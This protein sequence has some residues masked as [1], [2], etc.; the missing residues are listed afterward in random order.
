VSTKSAVENP[1]YY[2]GHLSDPADFYGREEQLQDVLERLHKRGS[3]SLV[4]ERKSGK[5][6]LLYYMVTDTA[7]RLYGVGSED[8]VFVYMHP[9]L[10]IGGPAGFFRGLLQKLAEQ[11]PSAIVDMPEEADEKEV[12]AALKRL[13]PRRLVLL[14]DEF[15]DITSRGGFS[16]DFFRILRGLADTYDVCFITATAEE[17]RDCCPDELVSSPFINIFA[18]VRLG[19][20]TEGEF[21]QFMSETSRRSRSPMFACKDEIQRLGGRFPFFVQMACHFYFDAWRR[22]KELTTQGRIAAQHCFTDEA[23]PYLERAWGRHLTAAEKATLISLAHDRECTG[24]PALRT[25]EQKGY[26]LDGHVFSSAL[27][28]LILRKES[29]GEK[30]LPEL[31]TSPQGPVPKGIWMDRT[32]GDVWVD[33]KRIHDLTRLEYKLLRYLYE[34]ANCLCDKYGLVE[35]VWSSDYI[36]KVD[37]P[38]IA[39]LVSRLREDVEPDP[40]NSRYILTVHGRGYR[41]V[42]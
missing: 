17:L 3:T 14:L 38:R 37:D 32:S 33:G 11:V 42:S 10:Q 23:M 26:V 24:Q 13:A 35:A 6:S 19:S 25:L 22:H 2:G 4:G 36:D 34:N 21:D 5:T 1:Y 20:W 27:N 29:S 9:G 39:K 28:D 41:L 15:Q 31:S 12:E 16:S 8:L 18:T 40:K 30:L 7:H